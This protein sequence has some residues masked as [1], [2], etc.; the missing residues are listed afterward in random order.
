MPDAFSCEVGTRL[1]TKRVVPKAA[2]VYNG[3]QFDAVTIKRDVK[4]DQAGRLGCLV[5]ICSG[6]VSFKYL[7]PSPLQLFIHIINDQTVQ[8][9]IT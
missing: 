5:A 9:R 7:D 1:L 8:S 6:F 4:A 3:S 2:F